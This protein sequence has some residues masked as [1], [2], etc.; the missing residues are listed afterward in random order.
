MALWCSKQ[1][2]YKHNFVVFFLEVPT[3]KNHPSKVTCFHVI[4]KKLVG[5]KL[6]F[7]NKE[8]KF[9][10]I[11]QPVIIIII[12]QFQINKNKQISNATFL[13]YKLLPKLVKCMFY[14]I[15]T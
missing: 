12:H 8:L 7:L 3:C 10:T 6:F 5:I 2:L 11:A 14:S 1:L 15:K 9:N 4:K 13:F